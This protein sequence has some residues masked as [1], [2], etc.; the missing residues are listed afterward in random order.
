M[1]IQQSRE[2]AEPVL[3]ILRSS[4]CIPP[5][6]SNFC[7]VPKHTY[8]QAKAKLENFSRNK[9]KMCVTKWE[10]LLILQ[11]SANDVR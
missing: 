4:K 7:T 1:G 10:L 11:L 9:C 5:H 3:K 6:L 8:F 2:D